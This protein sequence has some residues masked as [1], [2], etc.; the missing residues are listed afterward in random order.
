MRSAASCITCLV[1]YAAVI[2]VIEPAAGFITLPVHRSLPK[3]PRVSKTSAPVTLGKA[4]RRPAASY[5]L[6][7]TG[8]ASPSGSDAMFAPAA[9]SAASMDARGPS[10]RNALELLME[11]VMSLSAKKA[12]VWMGFFALAWKMRS[13]Y[14]II[15]GTFVLSYIGSTIVQWSERHGNRALQYLKLPKLPRRIWAGTYIAVVLSMLSTLTV[16]SVPRVVGETNYLSLVIESE[17]PYVFVADGIREFLGPEA[18]SNLEAFLLTVTGEEG[19]AFASGVLAAQG[20][21]AVESAPGK[22]VRMVPG[23]VTNGVWTADR[24]SRFAKVSAAAQVEE[25]GRWGRDPCPQLCPLSPVLCC[26][27]G[28]AAGVQPEGLRQVGLLPVPHAADA[29]HLGRVQ[30]HPLAALLLHDHLGPAEARLRRPQ[31]PAFEAGLCL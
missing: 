19:R 26:G 14:G 5:I 21:A 10:N 23:T 6:D 3:P 13:F 17:N 25:E 9:S 4:W 12:Y 28:A 22:V 2:L 1:A 11:M 31:A 20:A 16:L 24:A 8:E 18:M 15:L 27:R 7:P 30:G 29:V